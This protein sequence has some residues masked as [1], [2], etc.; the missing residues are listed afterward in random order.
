MFFS[1]KI[2]TCS[3]QKS[4]KIIE[5]RF[6]EEEEIESKMERKKNFVSKY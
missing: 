3:S 4:K 2:V 1:Y 6:K 5:K